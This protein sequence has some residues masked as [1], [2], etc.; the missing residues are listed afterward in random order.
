MDSAA[1]RVE[2]VEVTRRRLLDAARAVFVTAGYHGATLDAI[3]TAAGLT[4]G[5]VYSRFDGK[6]DLFLALLGERI[7]ER[8][9][10]V[11]AVARHGR[12]RDD[13]AAISRQWREILGGDLAWTLLVMEFRIHAARDPEVNRRY[14]A[15]HQRYRRG[16]ADTV[17]AILDAAGASAPVPVDDLV[18]GALAFGEGAALERAADPGAIDDDA[19]DRLSRAL[20]GLGMER[21][22][23]GP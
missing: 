10:Q 21:A 1:S 9:A 7:E 18:V 5:A 15:L 2:Q 4:K 22:E 6:A 23:R 13:V 12:V 8:L 19:F 17:R 11:R 16:L 20:V 14:A 3:A